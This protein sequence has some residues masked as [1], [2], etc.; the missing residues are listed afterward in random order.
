[1]RELTNE[2]AAE[3]KEPDSPTEKKIAAEIDALAITKELRQQ[4]EQ[5][6][7]LRRERNEAQA[8]MPSPEKPK[9]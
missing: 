2:L 5:V 6:D 1:M 4:Q 7:K 3:C 9:G 8:A